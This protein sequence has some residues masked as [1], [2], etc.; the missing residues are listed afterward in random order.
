M[1]TEL[2]SIVSTAV[3]SHA[4]KY[5]K[6]IVNNSLRLASLCVSIISRLKNENKEE[7]NMRYMALFWH[8]SGGLGHL[9][10][11]ALVCFALLK[12]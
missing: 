4:L 3:D 6:D 7:A 10:I 2:S 5:K 11:R 1:L 9:V 12:S 8:F